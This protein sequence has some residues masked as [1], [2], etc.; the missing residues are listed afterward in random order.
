MAYP[1]MAGFAIKALSNQLKRR[2]HRNALE[3]GMEPLTGMQYSVLGFV[4]NNFDQRDI[5]QKDIEEK[6]HIRRS[7]ATGILQLMEKNGLIERQPVACDARL[8]KIV[9]TDQAK[10]IQD[11]VDQQLL[12]VERELTRGITEDE[13]KTF[14][15]V[16]GKML[17]NIS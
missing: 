12:E 7:T 6:F 8:K 4:G 3:N 13:L 16:A 2:M 14:F 1:L 9:L 10:T 17:R 11:R 5:F 15:D